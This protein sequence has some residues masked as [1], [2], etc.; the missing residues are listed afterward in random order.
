[1]LNSTLMYQLQNTG[2]KHQNWNDEAM[3]QGGTG[4]MSKDWVKNLWSKIDNQSRQKISIA[5]VE[6]NDHFWNRTTLIKFFD[7]HFSSPIF[8]NPFIFLFSSFFLTNVTSSFF[9]NL[10]GPFV[11]FHEIWQEQIWSFGICISSAF[12][13]KPCPGAGIQMSQLWWC[14]CRENCSGLNVSLRTNHAERNLRQLIRFT[15]EL[16]H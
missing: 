4:S 6:K 9:R 13:N 12:N 7:E 11:R 1:M 5:P 10:G 8:S 16:I 3:T 14:R 2:T 15:V